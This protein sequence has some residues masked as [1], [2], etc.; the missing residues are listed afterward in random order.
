MRNEPQSDLCV[1]ATCKNPVG[2]RCTDANVEITFHHSEDSNAAMVDILTLIAATKACP[3]VCTND[4]RP[5]VGKCGALGKEAPGKWCPEQEGI[6]EPLCCAKDQSDCCNVKGR[7]L[8]GIIVGCVLAI[9]LGIIAC[10]WCAKCCCFRY[11]KGAEVPL[12]QQVQMVPMAPMGG[13]ASAYVQQQPMGMMSEPQ[14]EAYGGGGY[15]Q[16]APQPG[17]AQQQYGYTAYR[18]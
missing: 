17:H 7:A 8:A 3:D 15:P 14:G 16:Q 9:I 5:Y 2:Q 13:A 18:F 10:C 4:T 6:A 1:I 12:G 11:R